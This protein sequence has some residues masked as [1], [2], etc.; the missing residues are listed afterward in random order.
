MTQTKN[1][2]M[3]IGHI[4]DEG[5]RVPIYPAPDAQVARKIGEATVWTNEIDSGGYHVIVSPKAVHELKVGDI[6]EYEPYGSNFGWFVS[7]K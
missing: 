6:I 4:E 2:I 3:T 1:Q 5:D 7:K